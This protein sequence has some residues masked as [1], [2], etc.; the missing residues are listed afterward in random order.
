MPTPGTPQ[1]G[2]PQYD[3]LATKFF[4]ALAPTFRYWMQTEVHVYA[5]SIAANVL[6]SFFPFLIVCV[7]LARIRFDPKTTVAA[8]DFA[9]RDFFPD[10]FSNFL[11]NNLVSMPELWRTRSPEVLSLV[12][13]MFTANGIFEPLEVALNRVWGI[14]KNRSFLKNQLVSLALIFTCGCLEL[15]SLWLTA[16]N[17]ALFGDNRV[18]AFLAGFWL[19]MAGVPLSTIIV[20][21]V[22]RFLPNGKPPFKRVVP[23]AIGV[24]LLLEALKYVAALAWPW[25]DQKLQREYGVFRYS[26]SLIFLAFFAS[27]IVLAGAEWAARGHRFDAGNETAKE[28]AD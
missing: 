16:E 6:L 28:G 8:I 21:L 15:F 19:K 17:N 11:R 13:L 25:F 27:M 14:A 18:E 24:A 9:I 23:A 5:F 4:R 10:V 1:L 26:A 3:G 12:L 7:T 2:L 20:L 22:Y